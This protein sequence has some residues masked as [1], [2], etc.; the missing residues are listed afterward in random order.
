[1]L[2]TTWNPR[3][4]DHRR[5]ASEWGTDTLAFVMTVVCLSRQKRHIQMN[6]VETGERQELRE[7]QNGCGASNGEETS[8]VLNYNAHFIT[9]IINPTTN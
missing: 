3:H 7:V 9:T 2:Q 6:L 8:F 5:D 4:D 1:M